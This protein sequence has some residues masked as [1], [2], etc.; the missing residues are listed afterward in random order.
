MTKYY[1][2]NQGEYIGGFSGAIVDDEEQDHP[3]VPEGAVEVAQPPSH[4]DEIWDGN[5]WAMPV[6]IVRDSV[7]GAIKEEMM[8][9]IEQG[10]RWSWSAEEPE[11]SILLDARMREVL[12]SWHQLLN[13]PTPATNPHGGFIKS[14]GVIFKG[15]GNIDI[16][17]AVVNEIAEFAGLWVSEISRISIIQQTL[18]EGMDI[19]QLQAYVAA[20]IDWT[21]TWTGHADWDNNLCLYHP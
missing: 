8:T 2:D 4:A 13:Q 17:D 14:N 5:V 10:I 1:V 11:Y 9:R 12:A 20:S 18:V 15:P 7:K 21:V 19:T 6:D 3:D 16:P